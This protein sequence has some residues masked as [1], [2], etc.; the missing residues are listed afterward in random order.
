MDTTIDSTIAEK[1]NCKIVVESAD[2]NI[3][4]LADEVFN[5]R[6]ILVIPDILCAG[7]VIIGY[8]EWLKNLNQQTYGMMSAKS[9]EDNNLRF[10]ADILRFF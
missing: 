3:T 7:H 9:D 10:T 8:F 6:N 1:I 2:A 4:N 5:E